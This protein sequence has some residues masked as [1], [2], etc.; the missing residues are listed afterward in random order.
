MMKLRIT[1]DG[2]HPRP[3]DGPHSV[4][5][6]GHRSSA[7]CEVTWSSMKGTSA[8]PCAR[9]HPGVPPAML[10]PVVA[11]TP[12]GPAA[13]HG[14]DA[15]PGARSGSII[16]INL[17]ALAGGDFASSFRIAFAKRQVRFL[18][19]FLSSRGRF[20]WPRPSPQL[21]IALSEKTLARW[22]TS[23]YDESCAWMHGKAG[24]IMTI[25]MRRLI[26]V[27]PVASVL[28]LANFLALGEWLESVGVVGWARS[29]NA[30]Y[31][32]GTTIAVI[33][34]LLIPASVNA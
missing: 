25:K 16:I 10:D 2:P 12:N 1:P 15:H 30:E 21:A 3:V 5:R 32:T 33:A 11:G 14:D 26:V 4:Q 23:R 7:A 29:I 18:S 31:I 8:G 20:F 19:P 34:A 9:R 28:L 27:V 17:E 6:T 13:S 24:V 22:S